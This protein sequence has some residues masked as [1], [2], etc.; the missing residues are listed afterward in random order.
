MV[1]KLHF[2]WGSI[3][4]F[5]IALNIDQFF[6]PYSFL[7]SK[8]FLITSVLFITGIVGGCSTYNYIKHWNDHKIGED[9]FKENINHLNDV[10]DISQ[11]HRA[12]V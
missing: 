11:E 2:I 6:G 1:T 5:L 12:Y 10:L 8:P 3:A 7:V 9:I 4:T